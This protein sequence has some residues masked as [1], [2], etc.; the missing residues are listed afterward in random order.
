MVTKAQMFTIFLPSHTNIISQENNA[1]WTASHIRTLELKKK[2]QNYLLSIYY[3]PSLILN[4]FIFQVNPHKNLI[5]RIP[6]FL[7]YRFYKKLKLRNIEYSSRV[8]HQVCIKV[9]MIK[10]TWL[11]L[12]FLCLLIELYYLC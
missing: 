12:W 9:T 6:L 5:N 10:N 1:S 7:F 8:R 11:C 2:K 3:A 4:N